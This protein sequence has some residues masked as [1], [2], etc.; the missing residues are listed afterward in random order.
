MGFGHEPEELLKGGGALPRSDP[1]YLVDLVGAEEFAARQLQLP[2]ADMG[3]L[4]GL[5]QAAE[6]GPDGTAV[7]AGL[8]GVDEFQADLGQGVEEDALQGGAVLGKDEIAEILQFVEVVVGRA[9]MQGQYLLPFPAEASGELLQG[10]LVGSVPDKHLRPREDRAVM[11]GLGL[12]DGDGGTVEPAQQ[13]RR[14]LLEHP[15]EI[16]GVPDG[17]RDLVKGQDE[18]GSIHVRCVPRRR[19]CCKTPGSPS[20]CWRSLRRSARRRGGPPPYGPPRS[21][22]QRRFRGRARGR[23]SR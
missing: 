12:V 21:P 14:D 11:A 22:G 17:H 18:G 10:R 8:D 5:V 2:A 20:R 23:C 13:R 4:L 1:Q 16:E 19:S 7:Q 3:E 15:V 6:I 9:V